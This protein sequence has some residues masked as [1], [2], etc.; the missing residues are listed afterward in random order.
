M[1]TRFLKIILQNLH[2][3][4]KIM[5]KEQQVKRTYELPNFDLGKQ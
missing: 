4:E 5:L 2:D 3:V 1:N